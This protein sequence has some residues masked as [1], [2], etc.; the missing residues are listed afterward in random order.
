M[1]L[2]VVPKNVSLADRKD[3][4]I[5]RWTRELINHPLLE[6]FALTARQRRVIA[7]LK[8]QREVALRNQHLAGWVQQPVPLKGYDERGRIVV[9]QID[10]FGSYRSWA[11]TREGEPTDVKGSVRSV[12][13]DRIVTFDG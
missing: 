4:I 5:E 12:R 8:W 2:S 13:D 6:R 3:E 10:R 1:S 11:L 7:Y 9:Q